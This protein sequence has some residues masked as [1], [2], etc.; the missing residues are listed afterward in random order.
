MTGSLTQELREDLIPELADLFEEAGHDLVIVRPG[1]ASGD[2]NA[3][4]RRSRGGETRTS[5][6]GLLMPARDSTRRAA[7]DAGLP[8]PH[9]VAYL[10]FS[11]PLDRPGFLIEHEGQRFYPTEDARDPGGQGVAWVVPLGAPGEVV[12]RAGG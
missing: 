7:A 11:A 6:R 3:Q 12:Q 4:G 1:E 2:W 5:V 9:F 8:V 10:P